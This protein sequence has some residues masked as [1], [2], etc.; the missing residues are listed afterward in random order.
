MSVGMEGV[1][2]IFLRAETPTKSSESGV[3]GAVSKSGCWSGIYST[4]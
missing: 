2:N 4:K 1:A 3:G